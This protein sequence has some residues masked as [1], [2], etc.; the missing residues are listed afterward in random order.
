[1]CALSVGKLARR[2]EKHYADVVC[3]TLGLGLPCR[4]L[5]YPAAST[6]LPPLSSYCFCCGVICRAA[7]AVAALTYHVLLC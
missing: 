3:A 4:A 1:V 7:I 5:P 6:A 2:N